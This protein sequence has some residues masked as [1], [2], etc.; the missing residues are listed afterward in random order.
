LPLA[1]RSLS[2]ILGALDHP[3]T[4]P[5]LKLGSALDFY[6]LWS[7]VMLAYAVVAVAQVPR[8]R[9]LVGTLS[10]WVCYRLL[11]HVASGG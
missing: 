7:A 11:T 10:A 1:P 2:A 8:K 4:G 3:L 9:A 5:W 6:S